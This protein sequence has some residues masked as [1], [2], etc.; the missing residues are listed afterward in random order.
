MPTSWLQVIP[1][2]KRSCGKV[3]F[4][5]AYVNNSAHGGRCTPFRPDT[6]LGRPPQQT[7]P[8]QTPPWADTHLSGQTPPGRRQPIGMHS[9]LHILLHV[10]QALV[11]KI[12]SLS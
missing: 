7:P 4:S 11:Q 5:Q 9:C 6:P 8:G 3:M 1:V 10:Y 2:R 12:L